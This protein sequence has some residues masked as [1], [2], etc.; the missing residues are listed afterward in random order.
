MHPWRVVS[1]AI[2][3]GGRRMVSVGHPPRG[4][5]VLVELCV[6]VVIGGHGPVWPRG[7]EADVLV[8]LRPVQILHLCVAGQVDVRPRWRGQPA[9]DGFLRWNGQTEG[10]SEMP[11]GDKP[12][13]PSRGTESLGRRRPWSDRRCGG[14]VD[15]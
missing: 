5:D 10:M 9:R 7:R 11:L 15:E 14:Y 8:L 1:S 4:R 3:V 12:A 6:I 2:W 13:S